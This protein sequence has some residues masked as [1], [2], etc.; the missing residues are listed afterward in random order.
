MQRS[1]ILLNDF[2][3][4]WNDI[5][6]EALE[7]VDR[8]G[9]SGWLILGD[10]VVAFERDLALFS[11]IHFCIGVANGLDAIEIGLR[12][13]GLRPGEKVLTTPLSAFATTLAIIRSGGQPVFVDTDKNGLI[14]LDLARSYLDENRDVRFLVPVHL[15]GHAVDLLRLKELRDDFSL[16]VVEDCAQSI[17]AKSH[18]LPVGTIG[19]MAATSFYPTK[20]LG[21]LGDGGA[22]LTSDPELAARAKT[23]RDYGQSRKYVHEYLGLNSRLDELQAAILR[24]ALLP[25]LAKFTEVRRGI[26]LAISQAIDNPRLRVVREADSCSSVWHLLPVQVSGQRE[27]LQAHLKSA[28]IMTGIH[29]PIIIPHQKALHDLSSAREEFPNATF[30]SNTEISL[31]IHPYLQPEEIERIVAACNNWRS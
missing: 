23:L 16:C 31:P 29:Y 20:N 18:N 13:L 14:D 22:L 11:E 21:C 4:L 25:R 19:Q 27:S 10:E 1:I 6:E 28:E 2:S 30:M 5:R 24:S 9:R 26:A 3:A 8:V 7:A 15:F 12:C 17:G